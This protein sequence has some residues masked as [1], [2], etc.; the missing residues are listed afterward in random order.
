MWQ[1]SVAG[2]CGL[3]CPPRTCSTLSMRFRSCCRTWAMVSTY[4]SA[5]PHRVAGQGRL[6]DPCIGKARRPVHRGGSP[7]QAPP[8]ASRSRARSRSWLWLISR[9]MASYCAALH[10]VMLL[11]SCWVALQGE[12]WAPSQ[13]PDMHGNAAQRSYRTRPCTSPVLMHVVG[14]REFR[15]EAGVLLAMPA[16]SMVQAEPRNVWG[17]GRAPSLP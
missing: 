6:G 11:K 17:W 8:G 7:R 14:R 3:C 4:T 2:Q 1:S 15:Q 16:D 12:A 9:S 13:T 5:G 10:G